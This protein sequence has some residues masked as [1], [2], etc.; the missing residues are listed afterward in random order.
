[1]GLTEESL[2]E[3]GALARRALKLSP[4]SGMANRILAVTLYHQAYMGI[5]PCS[6]AVTD[7]LYLHARAAIASDDVDEYCHWAMCCAH[8]LRKEH[9]LAIAS[10]RRGLNVNPSCSLLHGSMGTVL[11]WSGEPDPSIESNELAL[12]MNPQ[13]PAN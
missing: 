9:R 7:R 6:K 11:A 12:R 5:I 8:L 13:D 2:A 4:K 1:L 3:C 10:L